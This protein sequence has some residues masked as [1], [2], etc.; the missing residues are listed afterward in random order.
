[1]IL[2]TPLYDFCDGNLYGDNIVVIRKEFNEISFFTHKYSWKDIRKLIKNIKSGSAINLS[3]YIVS[4]DMNEDEIKEYENN[5]KEN[6]M[7]DLI[8]NGLPP[9]YMKDKLVFMWQGNKYETKI[10]FLVS[11][12]DLHKLN[13]V[14]SL[15]AI[16]FG[17]NVRTAITTIPVKDI[18]G[19]IVTI[20]IQ[21]RMSDLLLQNLKVEYEKYRSALSHLL[22][23]ISQYK[24]KDEESVRFFYKAIYGIDIYD[25][26][27]KYQE[28]YL[29]RVKL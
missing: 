21:N 3:D 23:F 18:T 5:F 13:S 20:D 8:L 28:Y 19:N 15:Q 7:K 29:P 4:E 24:F 14:E 22:M 1:M 9:K 2:H 25:E 27:F 26:N 10:S 6:V 11:L 17:Y 16:S 12:F